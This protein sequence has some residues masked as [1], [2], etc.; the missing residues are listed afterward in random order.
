MRLALNKKTKDLENLAGPG[1]IISWAKHLKMILHLQKLA[2][3]KKA[4]NL[5]KT[6]EIKDQMLIFEFANEHDRNIFLDG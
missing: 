4:Y 5:Y 3:F 2:Y 1:T 6:P